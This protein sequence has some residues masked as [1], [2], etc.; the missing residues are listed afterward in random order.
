MPLLI[1]YALPVCVCASSRFNAL[2]MR[3]VCPHGYAG[4]RSFCVLYFNL[5][6]H[7]ARRALKCL[8]IYGSYLSAS[9]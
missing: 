6:L 7:K 1:D 4:E 8:E 3:M 9:V 5:V 2:S